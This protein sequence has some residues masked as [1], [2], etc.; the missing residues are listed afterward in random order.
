MN[1][2][3]QKIGQAIVILEIGGPTPTDQVAAQSEK[4][5]VPGRKIL[6]MIAAHRTL[7]EKYGLRLNN[8]LMAGNFYK[9]GERDCHTY[10]NM[11]LKFVGEDEIKIER[12]PAKSFWLSRILIGKTT[13]LKIV[14]P[15]GRLVD[16][17][18]G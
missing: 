14:H 16:S 4:R 3:P 9:A 7:N 13:H 8:L 1:R 12:F 18:S 6:E 17:L 15:N 11:I 10:L 5:I 2:I